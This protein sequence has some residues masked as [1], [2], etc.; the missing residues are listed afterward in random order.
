MAPSAARRAGTFADATKWGR[1]AAIRYADWA[2]VHD[3]FTDYAPTRNER[4]T[5]SK[6]GTKLHI[7]TR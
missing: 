6:Y 7:I 4:A 1:T 2:Q 3:L 5:L